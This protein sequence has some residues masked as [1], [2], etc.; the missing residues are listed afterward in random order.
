MRRSSTYAVNRAGDE[1]D[2]AEAVERERQVLYVSLTRA[3]DELVVS[4]VGEPSEFLE[5][6]LTAPRTPG[7]AEAVVEPTSYATETRP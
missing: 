6:A 5:E 4:W 7:R 1:Q 2:R 3:R